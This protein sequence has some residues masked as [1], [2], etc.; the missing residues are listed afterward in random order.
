QAGADGQG[1]PHGERPP[2]SSN[3]P[4]GESR[5]EVRSQSH[6]ESR[7]ETRTEPQP[8]APPPSTPPAAQ[9]AP[10]PAPEPR[11]NQTARSEG[12][13][14]PA[15][16]QRALE[17]ESA[18]LA[19]QD[20]RTRFHL[21][22]RDDRL[23]RVSL[24]LTERAG[25]IDLMVRTDKAPTTRAL[26]TALPA[27]VDSLGRHNLAAETTAYAPA[28]QSAAAREDAEQQR[29]RRERRHADGRPRLRARR[30]AQAESSSAE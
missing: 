21:V 13:A 4:R 23:G 26:Q 2:A 18:E 17:T 29:D 22:V 16:P 6:G 5:G 9:H 10:A 7:S 28:A 14:E 12:A 20:D 27:L 15:S 25:L 11:V 8:P 24:N 3:K 30:V 1:E 19:Q